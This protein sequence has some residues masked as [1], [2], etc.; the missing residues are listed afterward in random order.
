MSLSVV[1]ASAEANHFNLKITNM[2]HM[3]TITVISTVVS[4]IV[5][6]LKMKYANSVRLFVCAH[7]SGLETMRTKTTDNG[8]SS[9]RLFGEG[10]ELTQNYKFPHD[11]LR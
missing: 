7:I 11:K 3:A 8:V 1:S 9:W 2:L 5:T 4:H 6:E 10:V